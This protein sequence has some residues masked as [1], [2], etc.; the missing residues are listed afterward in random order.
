MA[1][2]AETNTKEVG[3]SQDSSIGHSD[4]PDIEKAMATK[5]PEPVVAVIDD[6]NVVDW[7][8]ADDPAKPIN[9]PAAKKWKNV[10]VV[11]SLTLLT[12]FGSSMFAPA[13][14]DV[15]Q[16]FNSTNTLLGAFVVSVYVLGYAFGP[17]IIAPLSELYGRLWLYHINTFLFIIFNMACGL[18]TSLDMEIVFRFLAGF[19]GVAPMTVGSGTIADLFAQEE[20]G[21]VMSAWTLPILLGPT[22]GPVAGS[23]IG[24]ALGWRWDFYTLTIAAVVLWIVALILQDETYPMTLLER[25]AKAL[26]K[27]TGNEKFRSALQ[28]TKSPSELFW[29]NIIRPTK[30]LF[31]SPIVFLLSLY[32]AVCYGYLY[33]VFTTITELYEGIYGIS[34]ANVGL[35]FLGIGLGQF[36]GLFVFAAISDKTLKRKANGGEMKPEYRLPPLM[37]GGICMPIGLFLYGWSAEYAIHWIVPIIGTTLVGLAMILIFM[38]IGERI[39][40]HLCQC[41]TDEHSGTY[42]VD[43]YTRYAASAMAANT[44]L[45]SIGGAVLPLCGA[46]MYHRLGYGWGNSLLAFLAIAMLPIIWVFMRYGERIRTHPRFQLNL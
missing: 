30:M 32:I 45:R 11:S 17:L 13:V 16:D 44:V 20:R 23:Y 27:E 41:C 3:H 9:W 34:R 21:K 46:Q 31:L 22:L 10:F 38:P 5:P 36:F 15:M 24:E 29:G 18:A 25:K 42:L 19:A 33:L 2:D 7:E 1:T 26:R 40:I 4:A 12:P 39:F 37:Y 28:S 35:T 8:S 14:P 43:A 6:P